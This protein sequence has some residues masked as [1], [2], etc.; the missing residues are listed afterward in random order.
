MALT[1]PHT[2]NRTDVTDLDPGYRRGAAWYRKNLN[3]NPESRMRYFLDFEGANITTQ[4]FVNGTLAGSHVGGYVGFAVELTALLKSG[5]NDLLV[6]VS[7]AYN[8]EIIPSQLKRSPVN[9]ELCPMIT[10]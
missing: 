3:L 2:W 8:P 5:D 6:R 1:L 4:V 10:S 7:N 9:W